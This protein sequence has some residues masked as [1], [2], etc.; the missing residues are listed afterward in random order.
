MAANNHFLYLSPFNK[1]RNNQIQL[2][3]TATA[4]SAWPTDT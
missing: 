1:L 2:S 3:H 4:R